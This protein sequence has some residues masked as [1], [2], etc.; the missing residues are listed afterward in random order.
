MTGEKLFAYI[1]GMYIEFG[2][3][4]PSILTPC[5]LVEVAAIQTKDIYERYPRKPTVMSRFVY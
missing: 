4:N 3:E 5:D 1:F 2:Y